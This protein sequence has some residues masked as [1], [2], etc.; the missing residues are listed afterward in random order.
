MIVRIP[1]FRMYNDNIGI[2]GILPREW[3]AMPNL[4]EM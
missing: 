2:T 1:E 4:Y 3:G